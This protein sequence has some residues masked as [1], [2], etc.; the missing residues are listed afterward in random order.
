MSRIVHG[1]LRRA[2][3]VESPHRALDQDLVAAGFEVTRVDR[4]PDEDELVALLQRHRAQ[5][6]F[7]RSRVEV[8]RRVLEQAPELVAIQ[9]CSIGDDSVDKQA[10][11]DHGVLVFNDPI[12]NGRSVVELA[13]GHLLALGRRLYETQEAS[14]AGVWDKSSRE[15]YELQG[16]VL[17][18]VG[19][20]NI[21]RAVARLA[22]QVGMRVR[23]CDTREVAQEVGREMG[24]E[25]VDS[26]DALFAGSDAVT[27]HLSATDAW[28]RSNRGC[29]RRDHLLALGA[30]RPADSPRL[31]LNL[32]RGSLHS[33]ED[34]LHAV[35]Q[36]RVRRA[37]VD[38]YPEEPPNNGPGWANPYAQ[39]PR[40]MCT[41]H[42]GAATEEAQPRIARRV[43]HTQDLF[44]RHAAVRDCV[45]SPRS[46]LS[47]TEDHTPGRA[48]LLVV[49]STTRGTKRYLDD[50]IYNAGA[51]NLRSE[52]RDFE[53]WGIALDLNLLDRP[54]SDVQLEG[55]VQD[56]A[57][58]TGDP[59]AVRL[60]RQI[61]G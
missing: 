5:V 32:A 3:I 11:A 6:L 52:H 22:E 23:F 31:F 26:L 7:K 18:V 56:A 40:V 43:A 12:S 41:P 60:V 37:A 1:A 8:T 33:S 47:M 49:H 48:M 46:T 34:L 38:V 28:G 61:V 36:G 44:S 30:D 50:A 55:L 53:S 16:K 54:L 9:L 45:Y 51:D 14:R 17:G 2:L 10:A 20:G 13:I 4:S 29:I 19:L 57:R 58:V 15:R 59:R 39:E 35:T 21:G 42:I 24:W 25:K 27:L